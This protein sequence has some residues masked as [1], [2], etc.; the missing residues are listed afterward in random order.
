MAEEHTRL[1][2]LVNKQISL[3]ALVL[4]DEASETYRFGTAGVGDHNFSTLVEL[5]RSHQ[6]RFAAEG[7]RTCDSVTDKP[8][9]SIRCKL[10]RELNSLL[11]QDQIRAP[12]TGQD[13][14]LRW[15]TL[16]QGETGSDP[17][18]QQPTPVPTGNSANAA[19]VAALRT[20]KVF[21]LITRVLASLD[22]RVSRHPNIG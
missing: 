19:T 16:P 22:S 9:E 4:G 17:G 3:P 14:K 21:Y 1:S 8:D 10:I 15:Q 13:R 7:V 5:R 18:H 6:T 11:R 20:G 12:G 2:L